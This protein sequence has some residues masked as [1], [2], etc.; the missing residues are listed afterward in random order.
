[1]KHWEVCYRAIENKQESQILIRKE[2]EPDPEILQVGEVT[3]QIGIEEERRE[4]RE[5]LREIAQQY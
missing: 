2:K 1:M 3:T 4:E 5:R